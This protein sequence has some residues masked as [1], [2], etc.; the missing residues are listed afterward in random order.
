MNAMIAL[1]KQME[2]DFL[3]TKTYEEINDMFNQIHDKLK[4]AEGKLAGT[5]ETDMDKFL[6]NLKELSELSRKTIGGSFII[7]HTKSTGLYR[8]NFN[9][10]VY[11]GGGRLKEKDIVGAVED[12]LA[13]MKENMK[14][15]EHPHA[16]FTLFN[17]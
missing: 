8:V 14:P 4:V 13:F 12:A 3:K 16:E 1:Q 10:A 5:G 9:N 6:R 2:V 7:Q 11:G 15:L 17:K